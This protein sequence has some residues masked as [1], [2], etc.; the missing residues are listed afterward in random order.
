MTD[1]SHPDDKPTSSHPSGRVEQFPAQRRAAILQH[2]RRIGTASVQQLADALGAS[3]STIRR[4]LDY[5][6]EREYVE[7]THGGA[8]IPLSHSAAPEVDSSISSHIAHPQKAAIGRHAATLVRP[9]QTVIFDSG[10]TVIEA[11]RSLASDTIPLR[12]VTNDLDV[13]RILGARADISVIVVGG[14]LRN[15]SQTLL[16]NPGAGF[17]GTL[18]A[19][20]A[21]LGTHAVTG[22]VLSDTSLELA[23][24]KRAMIASG[25]RSVV[26]ADSSKF[27]P[28]SNFAICTLDA[29]DEIVCDTG[30]PEATLADLRSSNVSLS[31]VSAET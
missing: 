25:K 28:P 14:T 4:D 26:L 3:L 19:D 30:L 13:A 18:Y 12:A 8:T 6:A 24:M 21:F 23:D 22:D 9:N 5:L 31:L 20:L 17:L 27:G 1:L 29:V 11:A 16:G 7:R 10:T 15:G 2:L